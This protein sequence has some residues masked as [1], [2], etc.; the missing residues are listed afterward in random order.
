MNEIV[1]GFGKSLDLVE[2]VDATRLNQLTSQPAYKIDFFTEFL[3]SLLV[4]SHREMAAYQ[5][6][7]KIQA[8][9][10]VSP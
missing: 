4:A 7:K 2:Q 5:K 1:P 10:H 3:R 6:R 8:V 9:F